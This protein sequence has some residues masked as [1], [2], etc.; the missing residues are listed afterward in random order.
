MFNAYIS[1]H[2]HHEEIRTVSFGSHAPFLRSCLHQ[3]YDGAHEFTYHVVP[4]SSLEEF[5]FIRSRPQAVSKYDIVSYP[6]TTLDPVRSHVPPHFAIV[7]TALKLRKYPDAFLTNAHLI[8][9]A[10]GEACTEA[11][12]RQMFEQIRD[13]HDIWMGRSSGR[14]DTQ[15]DKPISVGD[16]AYHGTAMR[17]PLQHDSPSRT[18]ALLVSSARLHAPTNPTRKV[19][20]NG[21]SDIATWVACSGVEPCNVCV[22]IH[23]RRHV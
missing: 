1:R 22:R 14:Q 4:R 15:D 5:A 8:I 10:H 9:Q 6:F 23:A 2:S 20:S 12:V 19:Q 18:T 13:L 7:N 11:D 16:E 21:D 3:L 17:T